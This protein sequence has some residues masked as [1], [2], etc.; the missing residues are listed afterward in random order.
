[1]TLQTEKTII[2]HGELVRPLTAEGQELLD[3]VDKH[4]PAIAAAAPGNDR[5]GRFPTEVFEGLRKDG[6]LGATVPAELGGLGVSCLHDVSLTLLRVAQA[7][8]STALALH[9]QLSR[10]LTLTY[11]W[12]HGD[13][14]ARSLAERVLR[15]MGSGEAIVSTGVKDIP[16]DRRLTTLALRDDGSWVLTGGKTLVS[17][18]PIATDFAVY[19]Q[20]RI[21]GQEPRSAMAVLSR[22]CPGLSV[23]DNWDGL[24]MRASGSVDIVFEE[25]PIAPGDVIVRGPITP[26][27]AML[28]GQ[29]VSSITMLGIYTGVA[30]A[31]H[32]VALA[33][34]A[35]RGAPAA[36]AARTLVAEMSAALFTMR[37]TAAA[38]LA[39][40]DR[41]SADTSGD[42]Q[43]RGAAMMTPFQ[44]AKLI[45]NKLAP[46]VVKDAQTIIG[47]ASYSASH[48]LARLYRDVRAGAFMQPYTYVDAVDYL[49]TREL[50]PVSAG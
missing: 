18:A 47:G 31:A 29:T 20:T 6:V 5:T 50:D 3:I 39:N 33:S 22:Q 25:C 37:S 34:L 45:I 8:A 28:A 43:E 11:D 23:L 24:G 27:L 12:T 44:C 40:A 35:R 2:P 17:L 19:A 32:D 13:P 9:M 14:G 15:D 7:D 21:D 38:A 36:A 42:P 49:S 48:P 1:M 41:L 26:D 4:V 46:A 30:Q 16:R 10:A